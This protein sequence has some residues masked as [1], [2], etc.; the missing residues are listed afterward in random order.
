MRGIYKTLY[1]D[2]IKAQKQKRKQQMIEVM[3][4]RRLR[5]RDIFDLELLIE[6]EFIR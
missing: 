2:Y 6:K 3:I 5:L 1:K 4:E